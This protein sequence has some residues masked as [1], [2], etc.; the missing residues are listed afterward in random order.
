MKYINFQSKKSKDNGLNAWKKRIITDIDF[1]K[2]F[3]AFY[4]ECIL[5]VSG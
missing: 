4:L 5:K 3:Y 2:A 1:K